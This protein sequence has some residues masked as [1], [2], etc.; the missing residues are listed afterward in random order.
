MSCPDL[1]LVRPSPGSDRL[2]G[3]VASLIARRPSARKPPIP[4]TC[5]IAHAQPP[6]SVIPHDDCCRCLLFI[7]SLP[8]VHHT[9]SLPLHNSF[10]R[11]SPFSSSFWRTHTSTNLHPAAYISRPTCRQPQASLDSRRICSLGPYQPRLYIPPRLAIAHFP[12]FPRFSSYRTNRALNQERP[13]V[14]NFDTTDCRR[15][16]VPVTSRVPGARSATSS[17]LTLLD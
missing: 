5:F 15:F 12:A 2:T 7:A 8:I 11:T 16:T 13:R 3:S 17:L 14:C 6:H 10:L 9:F 1:I 4:S